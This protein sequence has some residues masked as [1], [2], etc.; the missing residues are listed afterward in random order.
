MEEQ[1]KGVKGRKA[2]ENGEIAVRNHSPRGVGSQK[3]YT[4]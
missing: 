4:S 2:T 3:I 1:G